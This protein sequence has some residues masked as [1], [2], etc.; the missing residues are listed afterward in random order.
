M[1]REPVGYILVNAEGL[2]SVGGLPPLF[3]RGDPKLYRKLSHIK[4]VITYVKG[5]T[6]LWPKQSPPDISGW[7]AIPV[8]PAPEE[9]VKL[10]EA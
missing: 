6:H 4:G 5:G 2:V 1:S 8:Y 3:G 7:R 10:D 9:I